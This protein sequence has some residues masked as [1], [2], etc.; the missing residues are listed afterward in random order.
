MIPTALKKCLADQETVLDAF[1]AAYGTNIT[2]SVIPDHIVIYPFHFDFDEAVEDQDYT[3]SFTVPDGYDLKY[4]YTEIDGTETTVTVSEGNVDL[5][6]DKNI[7]YLSVEAVED[8]LGLGCQ[9][10]VTWHPERT[11]GIFDAI[12]QIHD[13]EYDLTDLDTE[14]ILNYSTERKLSSIVRIMLV[15]GGTD[16]DDH[17]ALTNAQIKKLAD[18]VWRKFKDG[19]TRIYTALTAEY[20]PIHNYDR[21]ETITYDTEDTHSASDDYSE[22]ETE[23][24]NTDMT[25]SITD[26]TAENDVYGFNST[27]PVHDTKQTTN[28]SQTT[29]GDKDDN[30]TETTR[31]MEGSLSDTKEG[32][33]RTQ[34]SGNIGVTTSAQMVDEEI[35]LRV[36]NQM[37]TILMRDLDTILTQPIFNDPVSCNILREEI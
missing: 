18:L 29:S 16:L 19:W 31:G 26:A 33:V 24:R 5:E 2:Y 20:N 6:P 10:N 3:V 4:S 8:A 23:K 32:T 13:P 17:L 15:N 7:T 22:T 25:S 12:R 21:D 14:Y 30:Y 11:T 9:I 36:S 28:S 27:D 1:N 35:R 37:R 34:T